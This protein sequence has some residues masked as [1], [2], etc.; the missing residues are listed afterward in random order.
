MAYPDNKNTVKETYVDEYVTTVDPRTIPGFENPNF[1]PPA[2]Y[3]PNQNNNNDYY[4][5]DGSVSSE[6]HR[7]RKKY[8]TTTVTTV[9]TTTILL[10]NM[11]EALVM[12]SQTAHYLDNRKVEN[13]HNSYLQNNNEV[14][15][16][17]PWVY[18]Q[19]N[20]H[21]NKS[22]DSDRPPTLEELGV[23]SYFQ[24]NNN[25]LNNFRNAPYEI[26]NAAQSP[27]I[28]AEGRAELEGGNNYYRS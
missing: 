9:T 11:Q 1:Y 10:P 28:A 23:T 14:V 2:Q 26:G 3:I 12:P 25:N 24:N 13:N 21:Y 6:G 27:W 18:G 5:D 20:Q 15:V 7:L 4:Y 17:Q 19:D 8:T 22:Q 16:R